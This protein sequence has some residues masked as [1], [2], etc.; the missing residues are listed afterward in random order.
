MVVVADEAFDT[1]HRLGAYLLPAKRFE[2]SA[3]RS[4]VDPAPILGYR[5]GNGLQI[6]AGSRIGLGQQ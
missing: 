6:V 1:P 4:S 5:G 2:F 3:I